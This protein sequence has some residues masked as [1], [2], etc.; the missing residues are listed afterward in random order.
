MKNILTYPLKLF[1]DNIFFPSYKKRL[2]KIISELCPDGSRVLDYGCDDG[3]TS[4]M[5]MEF[6]P[7]L[8]IVGVDIQ[9][10]RPSSIPRKLYDGH[11]IPYPDNSFDTVLCLDV[12]HHTKDIEKHLREL[13]RISKKTIII[14]D[15]V[16]YGLFSKILIS[17][18]DYTSNIAY[19][20]DCSYN[21][22][23]N[24]EWKKL[25]KRT[26]LVVKDIPKNINFGFNISTRYNPVFKLEKKAE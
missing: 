16:T 5:I 14:K 15:H 20:I 4:K 19:G 22:L 24:H 3:S 26:G 23:N 25:F 1:Y 18:T 12:L 13:K 6:N 2:A 21:F 10:N 11:K 8:N 17:F 7:C 9:G